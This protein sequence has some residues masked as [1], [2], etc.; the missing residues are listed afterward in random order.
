MKLKSF[1]TFI[2]ENTQPNNGMN[3]CDYIIE[4]NLPHKII[5]GKMEQVGSLNLMYSQI[6]SLDG[7]KQNGTLNLSYNQ[8][9][10]LDGFIQNGDLYLWNNQISSL[11]GFKQ[12][13]YLNLYNN[14]ISSFEGFKSNGG[15]L[16]L[17][18]N[19]IQNIFKLFNDSSKIELFNDIDPIRE[20]ETKNGKPIVIL[21]F[22]NYFLSEI[23]KPTVSSVDGYE[24]I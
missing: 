10:S 1:N 22:L 19:P 14:Q 7:F 13:G 11:D 17:L 20:P 12:N 24:C 15:D 9:S 21:D 4:N 5:N 18:N 16:I 8:I 3:I 2:N 23:G 6:S